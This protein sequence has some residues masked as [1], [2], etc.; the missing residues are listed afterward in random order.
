MLAFWI[1]LLTIGLFLFILLQVRLKNEWM[2]DNLQSLSSFMIIFILTGAFAF[3]IW[4]Y[5]LNITNIYKQG[6]IDAIN[7]EYK[8]EQEIHYKQSDGFI[9][10]IDTIYKRIEKNINH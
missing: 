4:S 7:G 1:I 8:Y 3:G 2:Y 10:P 5:R 9:I 6:Q